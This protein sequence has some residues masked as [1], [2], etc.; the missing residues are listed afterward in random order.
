MNWLKF[1][2]VYNYV[3]E[4]AALAGS[5]FERRL[6]CFFTWRVEYTGLLTMHR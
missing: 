5:M 3:H 4:I 6:S 2:Y 1:F